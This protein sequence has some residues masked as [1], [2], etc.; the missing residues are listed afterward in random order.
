MRRR[1]IVIPVLVRLGKRP[2]VVLTKVQ[3]AKP[4]ALSPK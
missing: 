3:V 1:P 2:Y 4:N